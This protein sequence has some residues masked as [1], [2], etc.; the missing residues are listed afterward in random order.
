[1]KKIVIAIASLGLMAG[2]A[3]PAQAVQCRA[4]NDW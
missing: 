3:T 1:V 2:V 4:T